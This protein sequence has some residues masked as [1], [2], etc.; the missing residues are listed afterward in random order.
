[1]GEPFLTLGEALRDARE[2]LGRR[3]GTR[4]RQADVA[5]HAG[6][7]VEWYA[8]IER[9]TVLPS[10]D[11]LS[12]IAAA[13]CLSSRERVEALRFVVPDL[14][15]RDDVDP[16]AEPAGWATRELRAY[17]RFHQRAESPSTPHELID[18]AVT[19]VMEGLPNVPFSSCMLKSSANDRWLHRSAVRPDVA[20]AINH[21]APLDDRAIQ[22]AQL[23]Q[24]GLTFVG[25]SDYG[26]ASIP[27][28][29]DRNTHTELRSGFGVRVPLTDAFIGY[30]RNERG[31]PN[32]DHILFLAGISNI[33]ALTMRGSTLPQAHTSTGSV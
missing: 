10:F 29:R 21:S 19:T 27:H 1:M 33:L 20:E 2:R 8:R 4:V 32:T 18:M 6:I 5:E 17:R 12:R 30:C 25:S 7:T 23:D 16:A 15:R 26:A 22:K 11:V 14:L 24:D 28:L 13:L 31:A 3:S 9:G